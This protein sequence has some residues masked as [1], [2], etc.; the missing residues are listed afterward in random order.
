MVILGPICVYASTYVIEMAFL[1]L[2]S[3]AAT[4]FQLVGKKISTK[5]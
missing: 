3:S 1:T 2:F 5:K 4:L